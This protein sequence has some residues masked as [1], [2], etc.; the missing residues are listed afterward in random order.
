MDSE[1]SDMS[2]YSYHQNLLFQPPN[3]N[4]NE[5]FAT[6]QDHYVAVLEFYSNSVSCRVLI[7]FIVSV[8]V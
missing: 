3:H 2:A 7:K 5:V 1:T 4:P 6:P 8:T